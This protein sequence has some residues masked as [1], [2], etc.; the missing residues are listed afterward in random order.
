[1]IEAT[2]VYFRSEDN[3]SITLSLSFLLIFYVYYDIIKQKFHYNT[4][5]AK[6]MIY[7]YFVMI[8]S[9]ALGFLIFNFYS[10]VF[11]INYDKIYNDI[12]IRLNS[13]SNG[14]NDINDNLFNLTNV[15][16]ALTNLTNMGN[17][18]NSSSNNVNVSVYVNASVIHDRDYKNKTLFSNETEHSLQEDK[19]KIMIVIIIKILFIFFFA[20]TVSSLY[21]ITTRT[22]SL[23]S[24]LLKK[25]IEMKLNSNSKF[26]EEEIMK[27]HY[28]IK[29]LFGGLSRI[30]KLK[31]ILNIL[32]LISLIDPLFKNTIEIPEGIY[33]WIYLQLLIISE[34]CLSAYLIKIYASL[35]FNQNYYKMMLFNE[36]GNIANMSTD[37]L[38]VMRYSM[39]LTNIHVW[40][41]IAQIFY[42]VFFNLIVYQLF[43][44]KSN[45]SLYI[46]D[47]LFEEG[48]VSL[49]SF[50]H[51]FCENVFYYLVFSVS[52]CKG[53]V[54]NIYYFYYFYFNKDK[55]LC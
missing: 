26:D 11:E 29:S 28:D 50:R 41:N 51:K 17:L 13:E 49:F 1:M 24:I 27:K 55:N 4:I 38:N 40:D 21:R 5:F 36:Q 6:E 19:N 52:F 30:I 39:T 20:V 31:Q 15:V 43:L 3:A 10:D 46:H 25:E 45:Y 47:L 48:S 44:C 9:I 34:M 23:D 54:Y 32:I 37:S 7:Y 12:P 18:T 2:K 53:I 16:D 35:L 8:F 42:Y 33:Y 14:G 22:A